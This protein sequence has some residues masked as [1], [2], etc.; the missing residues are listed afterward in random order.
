MSGYRVAFKRVKGMRRYY[1]VYGKEPQIVWP[2]GSAGS[3]DK[4]ECQEHIKYMKRV[5]Q[6]Q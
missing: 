6:E 2:A 5:M 4:N 3:V 1:V